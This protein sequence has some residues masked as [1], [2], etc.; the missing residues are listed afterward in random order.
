MIVGGIEEIRT[1]DAAN[2]I[3]IADNAFGGRVM[4][5]SLDK[6]EFKRGWGAYGHKL[7]EISTKPE[8]H[9]YTPN[10]PMAKEFVGH[11]TFNFSKDGLGLRRRSLGQPHPRHRQA[12]QLQ[13]GNQ[14]GRIYRAWAARPAAS[15]SPTTHSKDCCSSPT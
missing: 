10:G 14:D 8:D 5:F 7:S 11:L 15:C 3:Y 1:D 4:V 13:D 6:F 2:E 9:A 12:G